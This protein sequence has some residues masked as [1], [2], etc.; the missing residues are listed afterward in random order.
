MDNSCYFNRNCNSELEAL[1]ISSSTIIDKPNTERMPDD[2]AWEQIVLKGNTIAD[3]FT[4]KVD[5]ARD[6]GISEELLA[7]KVAEHKEKYMTMKEKP[8]PQN[9]HFNMDSHDSALKNSFRASAIAM[10][11][12]VAAHKSTTGPSSEAAKQ[13][14][15][16]N[17]VNNERPTE[18]SRVSTQ[19][20]ARSS[21]VKSY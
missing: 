5:Y 18:G 6:L 8:V 14:A 17:R 2:G 21:N 15:L 9:I 1:T 4:P 13:A 11:G 10:S 16:Q 7:A 12:R 19:A 3:L 20:P